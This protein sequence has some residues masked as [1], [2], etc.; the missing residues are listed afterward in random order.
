MSFEIIGHT[1]DVGLRA[2]AATLEATFA[3]ATRALCSISGTWKPGPG[4]DTSIEVTGGDV[5]AVLVDWLGEIVYLQDA[6]DSV[7]AGVQVNEAGETSATGS[8]TLAP[9]GG[10]SPEGTAVKAITYHQL[11]VTPIDSGWTARVFVDV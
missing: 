6:R 3:E 5:G 8:V 2:S 9:R 1:A 4:T 10:T 11:S 7:I